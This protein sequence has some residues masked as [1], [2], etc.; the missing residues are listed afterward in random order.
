MR[1][2]D[3]RR[4]GNEGRGEMN[5]PGQRSEYK[6]ETDLLPSRERSLTKSR[7]NRFFPF[8]P[9]HSPTTTQYPHVMSRALQDTETRRYRGIG[10]K[11]G[12][13]L[14]DRQRISEKDNVPRGCAD[15]R[16]S[17]G[18]CKEAFALASSLC[19]RRPT[20]GAFVG[21]N[22]HV[23]VCERWSC[24]TLLPSAPSRRTCI[25]CTQ[26]CASYTLHFGTAQLTR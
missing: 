26:L 13:R 10:D 6:K 12:C 11:A 24:V 17:L 25:K 8:H 20:K 18:G 16:S 9:S 5:L 7:I 3:E 2:D 21:L 4:C 19:F 14:G 22:M 15:V 23:Y 1:G